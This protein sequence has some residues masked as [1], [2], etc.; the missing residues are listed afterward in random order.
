MSQPN[1]YEPPREP[2]PLATG[3]VV[4]RGVGVVAILLLTPVATFAALFATCTPMFAL[5]YPAG[6]GWPDEVTLTVLFGP[7]GV[8]LAAMLIWAVRTAMKR[9]IELATILLLMPP[10]ALIALVPTFVAIT[11]FGETPQLGSRILQVPAFLW[12]VFLLPPAAVVM[13]MIV[14]AM[15]VAAK[16]RSL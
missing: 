1:P 13:S 14:W 11:L 10:A 6:P 9:E 7:A 15:R 5:T 12:L 2:E 4:K 16:R 8:V 3:K